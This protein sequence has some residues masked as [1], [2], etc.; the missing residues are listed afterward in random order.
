[1]NKK[2]MATLAVTLTLLVSACSSTSGGGSGK[3]GVAVF[4]SSSANSYEQAQANGAKA[5]AK[6]LNA[7]PVQVF[8]GGFDST[9]QI[10]QIQDATSSGR[11]K[12]FV[13]EPIDGAAVVAPLQQAANQGIKVVCMTSACGTDSTKV[14]LQFPRQA[15]IVAADYGAVAMRL[16]TLS[17]QACGDTKPCKVFYLN[18][19]STFPSDRAAETGFTEA[20]K[21]APANVD[22]V[23]AQDGKYDTGTGRS[24]AQSELQREPGLSVI[25]SLA[26]QQTLGVAQAIQAAGKT[27]SI[28]LISF[29]GSS[30]ALAAISSGQ[31]YGALVTVPFS[32]GQAAAKIAI[33]SA[34]GS[35]PAATVVDATSL[36]TIPNGLLTKQ[37]VSQFKAQWTS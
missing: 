34:D 20:M 30:Q 35:K 1:M 16:A 22:Y 19:D 13:I 26:D 4:L 37:D 5:A 6:S 29:G 9:K 25:A 12:A 24:I 27:G 14:S 33:E 11:Y 17:I 2:W 36:A 10:G 3:V 15:G 7:G 8:D 18:G 28:K 32:I 21:A 31:W 23:G